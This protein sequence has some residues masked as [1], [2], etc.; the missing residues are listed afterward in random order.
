MN[1]HPLIRSP[2]T[3]QMKPDIAISMESHCT[4]YWKFWRGDEFF[5][6]EKFGGA[7]ENR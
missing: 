5:Q 3:H 2:F 1:I 7:G 6:A 4:S